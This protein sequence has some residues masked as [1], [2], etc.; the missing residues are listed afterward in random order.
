V[1][2]GA[3][4][5]LVGGVIC[6]VNSDNE[7]DSGL[8]NK[9]AGSQLHSVAECVLGTFISS[10]GGQ[11]CGFGGVLGGAC[12]LLFVF[13]FSSLCSFFKLMRGVEVVQGIILVQVGPPVLCASLLRGTRQLQ[14]A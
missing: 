2:G 12:S 7:R 9:A 8:L 4:P 6:L 14:A 3:W 10:C 1:D 11:E 13:L 5:F